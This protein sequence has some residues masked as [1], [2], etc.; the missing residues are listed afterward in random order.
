MGYIR[1][2]TSSFD[3]PFVIGGISFLTS[4]LMH[5]VLMWINHREKKQLKKTVNNIQVRTDQVAIDV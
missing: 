3:I 4:A 5:F 1:D 2:V